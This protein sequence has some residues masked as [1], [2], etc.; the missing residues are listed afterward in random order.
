MNSIQSLPLNFHQSFLPDRHLIAKL[1]QFAKSKGSGSKE[2]I[3]SATGIPTGAKSGKVAPMIDYASAMGLIEAKKSTS[4]WQL[5]LTSLGKVVIEEDPYLDE[6]VTQWLMHLMMCRRRGQQEPARGIIDPYFALFADRGFRFGH[7]F[8]SDEYISFLSD[9]Y[10]LPTP[11]AKHASLVLRTY[12]EEAALLLTGALFRNT[13]GILQFKSAPSE[14]YFYPLYAAFL[15]ILWDEHFPEHQQIH[16]DDLF[17][18]TRLLSLFNWT[19][20]DV[21]HW[22]DLITDHQ[23]IQLDRQTGDA[24]ALRLQNTQTSQQ[25]IKDIYSM[26]L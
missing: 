25:S 7:A 11:P 12:E 15:L 19:K 13:D 22:L 9:R 21:K 4:T 10:T 18:H 14:R 1:L 8:S 23:I 26:I 20:A 17:D 5:S 6:A 16:L 2:E 24:L 3:S